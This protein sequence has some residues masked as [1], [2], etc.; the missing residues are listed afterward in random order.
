MKYLPIIT[1]VLLFP[2]FAAAQAKKPATTNDV[3]HKINQA[4]QQLDKLTPEQK[5]M[6]EQAW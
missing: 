3:Q 2:L 4:Q 1:L 5:K 6:M